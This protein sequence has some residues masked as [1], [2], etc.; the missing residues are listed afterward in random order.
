MLSRMSP[1]QFDELYVAG[2]LEPWGTDWLIVLASAIGAEILNKITQGLGADVKQSDLLPLDYFVPKSDDDAP[3][4]VASPD[5]YL[6]IM[7]GQI[8][9]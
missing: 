4:D 5:S 8:G 6:N 2:Q 1:A 9:I 3:I 7:R